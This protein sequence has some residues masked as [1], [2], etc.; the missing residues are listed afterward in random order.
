MPVPGCKSKAG[1]PLKKKDED[2]CGRT[3]NM[4]KGANLQRTTGVPTT[5]AQ[6]GDTI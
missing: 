4:W 1:A 6:L 5:A 3:E 2:H